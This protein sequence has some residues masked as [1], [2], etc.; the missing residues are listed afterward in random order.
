LGLRRRS[1]DAQRAARSLNSYQCLVRQLAGP[2]E[3]DPWQLA[4][5][6]NSEPVAKARKTMFWDRRRPQHLLT[7]KMVCGVC[8]SLAAS[9][10]KD[11]IACSAARRQGTCTNRASVRRSKVETWILDALRHQLMAPDLVAEFVRS[12]NEES[13]RR[14]RDRDGR[15]ASLNREL[16]ES[17]ARIDTLLE[18]V[19][20]GGLKGPSVLAKLEA[21]EAR[22]AELARELAGLK[23]DPVRLHPN[24]AALY[25]RKVAT[26]HDLLESDGTRTEAVEIIRSLVDQVTFRPTADD[27]LEI[28]L[29]GHLARMVHLAQNPSEN[30]P[31]AGAVPE[32]FASSVKVVAGVGFE[33]TTFRL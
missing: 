4:G 20:S 23:D 7:G 27:A 33:P 31:I 19:A 18:S 13:N 32:E 17:A 8:G 24:L 12:F 3:H 28:E 2:V 26:L 14:R 9:I 29:V 1:E 5:I 25:R 6:R 21:L 22:Q 16:K 10:G 11:Y 30:S 15:R